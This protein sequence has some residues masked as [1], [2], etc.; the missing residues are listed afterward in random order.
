MDLITKEKEIVALLLYENTIKNSDKRIRYWTDVSRNYLENKIF[1]KTVYFIDEIHSAK[2]PFSISYPLAEIIGNLLQEIIVNYL[3]KDKKYSDVEFE[4]N[5]DGSYTSHYWFD[6]VRLYKEEYDTA[7]LVAKDFPHA[8][9]NSLVN[10]QLAYKQ[11]FKR[12]FERI[13]LTYW[14]E[15]ELPHFELYS[16]NKKNQKLPIEL[17][18]EYIKNTNDILKKHYEVTNNGI[19]KDVWKPWNKII[20]SIPPNGYLNENEDIEYYLDDVKLEK[21]FFLRGY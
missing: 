1:N 19:L 9:A 15:N 13:V 10:H 6:E 17:D 11:K 2:N 3:P 4:I 5:P 8:E 21:D 20:L 16:T 14:I 18:D 12:K 7:M